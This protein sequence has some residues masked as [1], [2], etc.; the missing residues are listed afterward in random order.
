MPSSASRLL[1]RSPWL[2][3]L[4]LG[5]G[6]SDDAGPAVSSSGDSGSSTGTGSDSTTASADDTT[7]AVATTAVSGSASGDSSSGSMADSTGSSSTTTTAAEESSGGSSESTGEPPNVGCA[8]GEREALLDD[9]AYPDIAACNG[10]W[11]IPGV[12]GGT[13]FCDHAGGDDGPI[14]DGM[15][16]AI[17]DL[18]AEGWHLCASAAEVAGAGV[19]DCDALEWD[20]SFYATAQSGVSNDAC[21]PNGTNDVFGCGDIGYTAIS[22]CGA[23]NRSTGNLCGNL[24]DPWD[25]DVAS[26]SEAEFLVKEM[27]EL[28]GALCCR[29]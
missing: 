8:D 6:C 21:G 20:G 23:L 11:S 12:L 29:D 26:D 19:A 7:T 25:C 2:L 27:P 18:C 10:S 13:T 1:R 3:L 28:G 5:T 15:G 4:A 24:P 9:V 22:G 16:C 17:D 14:L